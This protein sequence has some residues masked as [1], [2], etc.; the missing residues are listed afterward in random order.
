MWSSEVGKEHKKHSYA[1]CHATKG[2]PAAQA[3]Y[4]TRMRCKMLRMRRSMTT[5]E[6]VLAV[7]ER[8][9]TKGGTAE[10]GTAA[11]EHMDTGGVGGASGSS[12]KAGAR[13]GGSRGGGHQFA[14]RRALAAY[15]EHVFRSGT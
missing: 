9:R 14:S 5:R 1:D 10:Q 7:A 6:E 8:W 13:G 15:A 2:S 11:H 3:Q 4:W 12:G